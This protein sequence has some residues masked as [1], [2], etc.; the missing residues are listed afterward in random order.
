[1]YLY[2]CVHTLD[3]EISVSGPWLFLLQVSP[4][5]FVPACLIDFAVMEVH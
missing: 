3:P 5:L 1:M 2:I 4:D